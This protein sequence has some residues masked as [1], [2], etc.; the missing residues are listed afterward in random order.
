MTKLKMLKNHSKN[1]AIM[2]FQFLIFFEIKDAF[3]VS[4]V[5]INNEK[6]NNAKISNLKAI[7]KLMLMIIK[8]TQLENNYK[9]LT[10]KETR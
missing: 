10:K 9:N 4:E 6:L 7:K 1:M 5:K 8:N 2:V 3:W